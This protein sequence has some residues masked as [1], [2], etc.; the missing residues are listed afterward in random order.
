MPYAAQ[1]AMPP[2]EVLHAENL[3]LKGRVGELEG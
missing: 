1:L 2:A 3:A